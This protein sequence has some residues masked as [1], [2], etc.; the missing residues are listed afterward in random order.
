MTTN[1]RLDLDRIDEADLLQGKSIL[2]I[3]TSG[4]RKA[5]TLNTSVFSIGRHPNNS[6]VIND[7]FISRHHTTIAWLKERNDLEE[8]SSAYWIIDGKGSRSQKP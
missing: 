1:P 2:I 6:L 4:S 8:L 3:E 5:V 7:K